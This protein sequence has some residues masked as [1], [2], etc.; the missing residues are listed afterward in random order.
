[1]DQDKQPIAHVNVKRDA[2]GAWWFALT[3]RGVTQPVAGPFR[4]QLEA[5]AAG[6]AAVR[7]MEAGRK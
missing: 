3:W 5:A 6:Q 7:A 4:N 2:N 1:M